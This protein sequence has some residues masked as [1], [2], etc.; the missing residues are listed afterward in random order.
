ME[1]Y[2]DTA[3]IERMAKT[4]G[5][6]APVIADEFHRA[7]NQSVLLVERSAK[8]VVPVDTGHLRRSI[9][10]EVTGSGAMVVGKV[11]TNVPYAKVV[12]E[13]RG[14]GKPM[15]P[16][17]SLLK[18]MGRKGIPADEQ[19]IGRSD[20]TDVARAP[21]AGGGYHQIEYLIARAIGRRGIPGKPYLGPALEKNAAAIQRTFSAL[22][23]RIMKRLTSS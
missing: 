4:Y 19:F 10:H 6:T 11:G 16:P 5:N 23:G 21:R 12:E 9:T 1:L 13:G 3:S 15:P 18:W 17:G 14:A 7:M 22:P 8:Q 20:L 2:A